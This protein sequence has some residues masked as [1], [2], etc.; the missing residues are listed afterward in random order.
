MYQ[1]RVRVIRNDRPE[2]VERPETQSR[3]DTGEHV[4]FFEHSLSF[5]WSP[6][7]FLAWVFGVFFVVLGAVAMARS[8]AT[9]QFHT[10]VAGLHQTPWLAGAHIFFGLLLLMAGAFV[11]GMR[12]LLSL[13]GTLALTFGIIVV[14]EPRAMHGGLGVHTAHG[15]LYMLVGLTVLVASILSPVV[16]GGEHSFSRTRNTLR[17]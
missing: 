7:Q 14:I 4:S 17:R 12:G 16:R 10:S 11:G 1:R 9:G 8:G 2:I 3:A 6:A 5:N 15:V 13:L